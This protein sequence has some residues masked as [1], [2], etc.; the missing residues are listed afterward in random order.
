MTLGAGLIRAARRAA[1]PL[2]LGAVAALG[3]APVGFW[4]ATLLA[5]ALLLRRA[6][7][8]SARFTAFWAGT[9]YFAATLFWIVEPFFV[10]P[11]RDAWMA[12]FALVFMALGGGLFWGGAGWLADRARP[13]PLRA[14]GLALGLVLSDLARS[15]LFTGFPWVLLGHVWI[16][17]PVAQASAFAGPIGLSILT[18]TLAL[19][20]SRAR[21]VPVL[22]ALALTAAVWGGGL[23]RLSR[24]DPPR[25]PAIRVRLVQPNAT[26][27]LK[28]LPGM[29]DTFL[30]RMIAATGA[31][32]DRPLS[33]IVWPETSIPWLLDQAQPILEEAAL[34]ANGTPLAIGLQ[35]GDGARYY[36]TLAIIDD[37]GQAR[38]LYDKTHL[39]PFGEYVPFAD[40]LGVTAFAARAGNGYSAGAGPTVLDLGPAGR[41]LPLICY[42]AVFPQDLRAAEAAHGRADWILQ[43]T[44]DSWFGRLSGPWQHAAQARLRAI[45]Q[46]LPLLRD[47]NTGITVGY[48]AK[49]RELGRL[50]QESVGYLDLDVPGALPPTVYARTGDGPATLLLFLGLFWFGLATRRARG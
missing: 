50:A 34:A 24:T 30:D 6:G 8:G 38:Q 25:D 26:Q 43:V 12:P 40:Q 29:W 23:W 2:A 10:E 39:V 46:G 48:D 1:L 21:P 41:V 28:W 36:N 22:S 18:A 17:T 35:R 27:A 16:A 14:L 3:Q 4:P 7:Q 47:A 33:L 31:P 13:G 11:E 44:N 15:Y 42:E 45:E 49:G 37:A 20:L 32:T 5:L 9:G 19:L